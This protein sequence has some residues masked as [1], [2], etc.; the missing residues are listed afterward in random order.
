MS[1]EI[2]AQVA[3]A[4]AM[5]CILITAVIILV[6]LVKAYYKQRDFAFPK[7]TTDSQGVQFAISSSYRIA[8]SQSLILLLLSVSFVFFGTGFL[9]QAA[10]LQEALLNPSFLV[11]LIFELVAVLLLLFF[12]RSHTAVAEVLKRQEG[13]YVVREAL[14]MYDKIDD[15]HVRDALRLRLLLHHARISGSDDASKHISET[16]LSPKVVQENDKNNSD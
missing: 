10:S 6:L 4:I 3:F 8:Q 15:K 9:L 2:V 11:G 13:T 12:H 7:T 1:I 5:V 16:I 14:E